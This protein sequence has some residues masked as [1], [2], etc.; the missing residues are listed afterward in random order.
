MDRKCAKALRL[1]TKQLH[2][3]K[4][5]YPSFLALGK[6]CYMCS[7]TRIHFPMKLKTGRYSIQYAR[8]KLECHLGRRLGKQETVDH[9]DGNGSN[10]KIR[11]LQPLSRAEN[12]RKG[13]SVES[14]K[15]SA[16]MSRQR[17]LG[18]HRL[19]LAG[20]NNAHSKLTEVDVR[21]IKQ[22][23]S[24]PY[25]G[26]VSALAIAYGV[27]HETISAIKTGKTWRHLKICCRK[28]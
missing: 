2:K 19:D 11:N 15:R 25:H 5:L 4:A 23:L 21:K 13:A 1:M 12:A 26:Q 3:I 28:T 14:K 7:G 16:E 9:I 22:K 27:R 18:K 10:N 17:L 24:K 8:L 6:P 20:S